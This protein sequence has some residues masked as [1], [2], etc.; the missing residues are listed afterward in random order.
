MEIKTKIFEKIDF[1]SVD[2]RNAL[3]YDIYLEKGKFLNN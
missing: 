1:V 3:D 2:E